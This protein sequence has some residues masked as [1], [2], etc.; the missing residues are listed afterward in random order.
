MGWTRMRFPLIAVAALAALLPVC[1][2]AQGIGAGAADGAAVGH[3]AAGPVGGAVGA[4]VGG[5]TGGVVGGVKG[6]L[7]VPQRTDYPHR[8]YHRYHRRYR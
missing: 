3:R 5:V 1:A 2:Q 8:R 4:V 7:G 6:V